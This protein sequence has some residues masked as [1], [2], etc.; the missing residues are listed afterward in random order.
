MPYRA[1]GILCVLVV[2][3]ERE[4][5]SSIGA[6]CKNLPTYLLRARMGHVGDFTP[7]F[8]ATAGARLSTNCKIHI[9]EHKGL[10]LCSS[11][12]LMKRSAQP[13]N[14]THFPDLPVSV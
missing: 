12:D 9:L 14:C 13:P 5:A 10:T 11:K 3:Y 6:M 8:T 4:R 7:L 2:N 1:Q